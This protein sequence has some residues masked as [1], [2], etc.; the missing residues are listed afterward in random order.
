[1]IEQRQP[2]GRHACGRRDLLLLVEFVQAG[3]VELRAGENNLAADQRRRIGESPCVDME[4]RHHRQQAIARRQVEHVRGH[5]RV[6]VE[7][8]RA[9]AVQHALRIAGR[10]RGVTETRSGAFVESRPIVAAV[11]GR[12]QFI[13]A[14]RIGQAR[15][16][17]R[18]IG[19]HDDALQGLARRCQFFNQWHERQV[20]E[21]EF[22][23]R[24]IEDVADLVLEQPRVDRMHDRAAPGRRKVELEVAEPVPR[25]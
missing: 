25:K 3:A 18:A 9:M 13:E 6:A 12:N 14:E 15:G 10:A 16:H 11:L 4:H 24:V 22:V 5:D 2:D 1:M 21:Q 17:V 8:R 19:H 23:F 7:H 20:D